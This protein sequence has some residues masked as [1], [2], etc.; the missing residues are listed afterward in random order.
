MKVTNEYARAVGWAF[1]DQ[2]PKAV[3]AAIAVSRCTAGGEG[4]NDMDRVII[5]VMEEWEALYANGIVPQK[6][7]SYPR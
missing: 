3:W 5:A 6:P 7:L 1:Y 2:T 4:I